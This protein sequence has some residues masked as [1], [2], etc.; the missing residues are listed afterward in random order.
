MAR[1]EQEL[2]IISPHVI[3]SALAQRSSA[4]TFC[5]HQIPCSSLGAM[6][7]AQAGCRRQSCG[8]RG[9]ARLDRVCSRLGRGN[10]GSVGDVG[11][12]P[13]ATSPKTQTPGWNA[14]QRSTSRTLG[15]RC[16]DPDQVERI[17]ASQNHKGRRG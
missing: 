9:S 12:C 17:L 13:A 16:N 7:L 4:A 8:A 5:L 14:M 2:L 3:S 1:T 15:E 6:Q 10:F 11:F